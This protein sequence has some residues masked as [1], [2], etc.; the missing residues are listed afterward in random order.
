[1]RNIALAVAALSATLPAVAGAAAVAPT[2]V[3]LI[4][5][6]FAP[7][8]IE[9]KVPPALQRIQ[10]EGA[11]SHHVIP[12]FPTSDS[13]S[14]FT[15]ST[16]CRPAT[17]GIVN[18]EFIDPQRGLYNGELDSRWLTAC[19]HLH[20]A[21][22]RQGLRVATWDWFDVEGA[23]Q[24]NPEDRVAAVVQTLQLPASERPRLMIAHFDGPQDVVAAADLRSDEAGQAIVLVDAIVGKVI[25]AIAAL[26]SSDPVTL[27]VTTNHGLLPVWTEV[28]LTR[29]L[30]DHDLDIEF[31]AAGTTAF[32]YIKNPEHRQPTM[33]A[34]SSYPRQ[35][36]ILLKEAMP[37][38]LNLG[39]SDRVGDFILV[40]NPPYIIESERRWWSGTAWLAP[41]LPQLPFA[42]PFVKA[43]A[44]YPPSVRGMPGVL[45]A[46]GA[47]I[48][49][50][51]EIARLNLI[52][53]HPTICR[54]LGIDPGSPVDGAVVADLVPA[55]SARAK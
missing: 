47:G 49:D 24:T 22:Q 51:G 29:I 6:G 53:L 55:A 5:D 4:F 37:P 15:L 40:A 34:M 7:S 30:R 35:F 21:A 52:D 42:R 11:F 16:G 44:G 13:V 8:L 2:V 23:P 12:E 25:Q 18:D 45:Y 39:A 38:A 43:A 46:W 1:V 10:N 31:A 32:L 36:Q 3:M 41:W 17:H 27:L 20:S 14:T 48:P 28:N 19:E 54:M 26:P 50:R 33:A 9:S